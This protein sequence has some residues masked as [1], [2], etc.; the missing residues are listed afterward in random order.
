MAPASLRALLAGLIDYAGLFPP[1]E[2]PLSDVVTNYRSYLDS[3]DA[4]A[5][6]RLVLPAARLA[7]LAKLL[8]ADAPVWRVSALVGEDVRADAACILA[9][10]SMGR[11][12]VDVAELRASSP[13]DVELA[14]RVLEPV[15]VVYVEVAVADDP[16]SL[17][18]AVAGVGLRAKIRTGGTVREAF[19]T[20]DNCAQFIACCAAHHVAFKAT[21]GLHHPLRGTYRLTYGDDAPRGEMFGFLNLFLAGSFARQGMTAEETALVLVETDLRQ[22]HFDAAGVSW[23]GHALSMEQVARARESF[24]IS[25]GSCS[26]R[27]PIDDLTQL[28]LL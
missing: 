18:R 17:I 7:D 8:T 26:F 1:A 24:A 14:A 25:F 23:R 10:R 16:T 2:L 19:P 5:L 21:A 12:C 11:I 20:A 4:W 15:P 22:F 13:Q 3:P 9:A 6:G 28:G 27:E